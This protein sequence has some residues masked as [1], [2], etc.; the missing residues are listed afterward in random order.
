MPLL[1]LPDPIVVRVLSPSRTILIAMKALAPGA[2]GMKIEQ[3]ASAVRRHLE[4]AGT[5]AIQDCSQ[6]PAELILNRC[7]FSDQGSAVDGQTRAIDH[8]ERNRLEERKAFAG[9]DGKALSVRQVGRVPEVLLEPLEIAGY[10]VGNRPVQAQPGERLPCRLHPVLQL[11]EVLPPGSVPGLQLEVAGDHAVV[12]RLNSGESLEYLGHL[13]WLGPSVG[14][15]FYSVPSFP[16]F[17]SRPS[18]KRR[19]ARGNSHRSPPAH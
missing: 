9:K 5:G 19:P 7:Q 1:L 3:L 15:T 14:G 17:P 12:P 2:L 13:R 4:D 8:G 10:L 16:S 18:L 11:D 6:E